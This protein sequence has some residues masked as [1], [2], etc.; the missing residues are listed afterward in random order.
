MIAIFIGCLGLFGYLLQN[1]ISNHLLPNYDN[2]L[3]WMWC[4]LLLLA[5]ILSI[6][7]ACKLGYYEDKRKNKL[8]DQQIFP[9]IQL[10]T[11]DA[12]I[13]PQKH[14]WHQRIVLWLYKKDVCE[15][16]R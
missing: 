7:Y 1:I 13:D 4:G 8:I 2:K 9:D 16:S 10:I 11:P 12:K 3:A 6:S 15:F 14:S 5:S